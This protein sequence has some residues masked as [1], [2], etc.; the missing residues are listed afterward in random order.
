MQNIRTRT[1]DVLLHLLA[2]RVKRG[3]GQ[4]QQLLVCPPPK[5][6]IDKFRDQIMLRIFLFL[7]LSILSTAVIANPNVFGLQVG[8]T[9]VEQLQTQYDVSPLGINKFSQG[10]MFAIP[11]SQIDF[12]GV[13]KLTTI[14]SIENKLVGVLVSFPKSKFDYLNKALGP[15]YQKISE[16]IPFVGDK[17]VT[18]RNGQT[19]ITIEAPH[20][21]FEMSLNYIHDDLN[22][23]FNKQSQAEKRAQQ[24][25]ESSQL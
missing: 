3:I 20:M 19:E 23:A 15:K 1:S 24:K 10:P 18:Y 4:D 17:S 25:R 7:V 8:Q 6:R 16:R 5:K 12:E 21:S 13:Q 2:Y 14:F 22:Q 9:T 11:T